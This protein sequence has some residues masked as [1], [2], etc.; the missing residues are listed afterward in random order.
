M[1]EDR[2]IERHTMTLTKLEYKL[3]KRIFNRIARNE[4]KITINAILYHKTFEFNRE[5]AEEIFIQLLKE[6]KEKISHLERFLMEM[7]IDNELVDYRIASPIKN[8][9][10]S[11]ALSP[12][13]MEMYQH[14]QEENRRNIVLNVSIFSTLGIT[15]LA[16][17]ASTIFNILNL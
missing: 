14:K 1:N 11:I 12:K 9:V 4:N 15:L 16:L 10:Y 13:C 3:L 5:V 8:N 6:E 17:I 2:K 7:L